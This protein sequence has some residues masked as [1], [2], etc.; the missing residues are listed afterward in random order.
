[1]IVP[2]KS[3][4]QLGHANLVEHVIIDE[5][6]L[7]CL[8]FD[9]RGRA[10]IPEVKSTGYGATV[11]ARGQTVTIAFII[12]FRIAWRLLLHVVVVGTFGRCK[13]VVAL[14]R[15]PRAFFFK[16]N[17]PRSVRWVVQKSAN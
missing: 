1:M 9:D 10:M 2:E 15:K 3:R 17:E 13:I 11:T 5:P 14:G 8:A 7:E 6:I 16:V 4:H 12:A